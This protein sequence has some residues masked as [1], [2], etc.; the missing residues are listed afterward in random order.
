M[1][2]ISI[3]EFKQMKVPEIKDGGS[4]NLVADGEFLAIV[5]IPISGYKKGQFQAL[6]SQMNAAIGK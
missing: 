5:V 4:F 6:C 3:S 2:N 1:R